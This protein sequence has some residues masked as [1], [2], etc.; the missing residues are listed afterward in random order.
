VGGVSIVC[1]GE[2]T[3]KAV[4]NAIREAVRAVRSSMVEHIAKELGKPEPA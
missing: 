3:P 2:S 1:H 4:R